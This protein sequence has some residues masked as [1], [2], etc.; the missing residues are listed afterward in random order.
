MRIPRHPAAAADLVY[1]A[2]MTRSSAPERIGVVLMPRRKLN[3]SALRFLVLAMNKEQGLFQFEFFAPPLDDPLLR[4]LSS[5]SV[6]RLSVKQEL[7]A[8]A[9]RMAAHVVNKSARFSLIELESPSRFV[10]ISHCSFDDNYYSARNA[11]SVISL[12]NWKRFMAPP[13]LLEFVQMLLIRE[14][15]GTLCPSLSGSVHLGHKGCLL[16]F[17]EY[18]SEVRQKALRGFV[19]DF[20]R[21]YMAH[22]GHSK[23]ADIVTRLLD[24]EWLGSPTDPR[25]VAGVAANLKYDLFVTKG[26]RATP[27]E[28]FITALR[29]E[30]AKQIVTIIGAIIAAL[31]LIFLGLRASSGKENANSGRPEGSCHPVSLVADVE[32]GRL[33][34]GSGLSTGEGGVARLVWLPADAGCP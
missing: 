6:S 14:V 11:A 2:L 12:G 34:S 13:S 1:A 8:F 22:D 15:V 10:V 17:T 3:D 21:R 29:Q 27:R 20:C 32:P 25:S 18:L 24:R 19:C 5:K 30:G 26:A 23:L 9:E 33:G 28:V 4:R 7:P 31:V 16:D